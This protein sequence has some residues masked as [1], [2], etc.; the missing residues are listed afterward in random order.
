MS[1]LSVIAKLQC[2]SSKKRIFDT[3]ENISSMPNAEQNSSS[4]MGS[5]YQE[6]KQETL[7]LFGVSLV[8]ALQC[9]LLRPEF[10]GLCEAWRQRSE[11]VQSCMLDVYDGKLWED[12][13]H[14]SGQAFLSTA[15]S[16]G[17]ILNIDWF[18]PYKHR[19][20]SIGVIYLAIM[21]LPRAVRFKRE[22]IIVGLLPG[23]KEP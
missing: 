23:P 21:N 19:I 2:M 14:F 10:Y 8:S 3:G 1:G 16:I 18:Q 7:P 20:Y 22:N 17:F 15:N 5:C 11:T 9:L 6:R 12:F 4:F 13:L